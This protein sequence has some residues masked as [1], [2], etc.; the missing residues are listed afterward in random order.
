MG[1]RRVDELRKTLAHAQKAFPESGSKL[2]CARCDVTKRSDVVGLVQE[3]E[4]SLGGCDI[5]VN[6]AGVMYFTLMKNVLW[7]QW[8]NTVDVNCKGA[9]YGIGAVLPGMLQRGSGHI[10]NITSDSQ[11]SS[12]IEGSPHADPI[13][14]EIPA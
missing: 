14:R 1:A 10:V 11:H 5:L 9:M 12:T 3:T 4:A 8:D 6:C 13:H 2:L 7:D